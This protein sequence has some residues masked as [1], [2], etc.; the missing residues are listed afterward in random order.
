M[1]IYQELLGLVFTKLPEAQTWHADVNTYN[2]QDK[3]SKEELGIF[4]LDLYPRDNKY[5]HAAVFPMLKRAKIDGKIIPPAAA[6]MCNFDKPT[7]EKKSCLLHDDVVTFFHEF[8]HVMHV[9]GGGVMRWRV[10]RAVLNGWGLI[11]G[12]LH[13]G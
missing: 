3:V 6:M 12:H 7:A 4:Y 8:G 9:S 1:D 10:G 5:G 13:Q 2:V 11:A